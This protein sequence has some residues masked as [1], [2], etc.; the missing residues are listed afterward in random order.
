[1]QLKQNET[2]A[3]FDRL[4]RQI[5]ELYYE[6]AAAQGLSESAYAIFQAL[7]VLGDGCTQT[8]IY[9]YSWLNKQTVNS[10]V[11]RLKEKGFIAFRAGN[12]REQRIFLTEDGENLV[13]EK[14]LP[15]ERAENEVFDEMT[16]EEQREILRLTNKYLTSFR[17]KVKEIEK[18]KGGSL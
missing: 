7:L 18:R 3:E 14:I 6:L 16:K 5:D 13:A 12:G 1:M 10:S 4:E 17:D 9:K 8:D 11:K 2:L 15:Y